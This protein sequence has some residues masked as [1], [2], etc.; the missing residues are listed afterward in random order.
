VPHPVQQH[1][2]QLQIQKTGLSAQVP[3][4]SK[5][6]TLKVGNVVQQ[7]ITGFNEDVSEKT[8][9]DGHYKNGT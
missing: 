1:L 6:D 7:I 5:N 4:S 8:K 2:P 3:T 9:N